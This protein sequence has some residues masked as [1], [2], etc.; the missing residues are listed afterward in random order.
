MD[1]LAIVAIYALQFVDDPRLPTAIALAD[2]QIALDHCT[3]P[4]AVAL[5]A[6]HMLEVGGRGGNGGSVASLTE[7]GLSVSF[8]GVDGSGLLATT[9]FGIE[10]ERLN[11][12]CYGFAART[13]D[14]TVI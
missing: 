10:L 11:R 3:R 9:S 8:S 12:E 6:L 7:G 4:Q 5:L 13:A 14:W 1:P 2:Q